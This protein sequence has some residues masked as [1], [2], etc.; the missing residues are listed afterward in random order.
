MPQN[1]NS[2][3]ETYKKETNMI[4]GKAKGLNYI[5]FEV[6]V[7]KEEVVCIWPNKNKVLKLEDLNAFLKEKFGPQI[8]VENLKC[9]AK[10]LEIFFDDVPSIH[11]MILVQRNTSIVN[12]IVSIGHEAN[13]CCINILYSKGLRLEKN[14]T[15][16]EEP[17]C[18]LQEYLA[19]QFI[20]A[21][22]P[23]LR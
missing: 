18:Y 17:F 10:Y 21:V 4:K 8:Q 7:Y 5:K 22:F 6:D 13:H 3:L 20:Q 14:T 15:S 12:Q 16:S 11:I 2:V 1:K 23:S 9:A 19:K